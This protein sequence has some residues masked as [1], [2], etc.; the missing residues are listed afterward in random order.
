MTA[1]PNAAHFGVMDD[2]TLRLWQAYHRN[3]A[4]RE[5]A[6]L[7]AY[8]AHDHGGSSETYIQERING[9]RTAIRQAERHLAGVE[10]EMQRRGIS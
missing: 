10:A 2:D 1:H 7:D 6:T 3:A 5:Q 8:L 9:Y 4:A